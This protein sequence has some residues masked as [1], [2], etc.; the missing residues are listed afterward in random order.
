MRQAIIPR[1][2]QKNPYYTALRTCGIGEDGRVVIEDNPD[3]HL[4]RL[5]NVCF[6]RNVFQNMMNR[7][8]IENIFEPCGA[9]HLHEVMHPGVSQH[10][11]ADN[12]A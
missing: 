1:F 7:E 9:F 12:N 10:E 2:Q 11:P 5:S 8:Y 4:R 6:N 3:V